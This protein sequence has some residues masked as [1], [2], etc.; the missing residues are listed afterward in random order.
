MRPGSDVEVRS[1]FDGSWVSGF[2]VAD[3]TG[4]AAGE[5]HLRRVSDGT[6]LP[7]P[8]PRHELRETSFPQRGFS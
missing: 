5:F 3:V 4:P 7:V 2:Q 8:F 6:V 1:S